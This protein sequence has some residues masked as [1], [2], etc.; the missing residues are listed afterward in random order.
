MHR[1]VRPFE[2]F[3]AEVERIGVLHD[4]LS[5]AHHT[6]ARADLVTE[7]RLDLVEVDRQLLVAA[8]LAPRDVGNDFLM[9]RTDTEITFVPILQAQELGAE[10]APP[11]GFFPELG[12][13]TAGIRTSWAPAAFISSRTMASTFRSTRMPSGSHV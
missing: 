7:F 4:E 13:L 11:P 1:Q 2:T 9:G 6:E 3:G 10:V 5:R 12:W 8:H